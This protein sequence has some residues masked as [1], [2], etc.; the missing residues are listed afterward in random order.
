M[1]RPNNDIKILEKSPDFSCQI[2]FGAGT[3]VPG[4][5]GTNAQGEWKY[6]PQCTEV[7]IN[8]AKETEVAI[9]DALGRPGKKYRCRK[10]SR[11]FVGCGVCGYVES[12]EKGDIQTQESAPDRALVCP[13]CDM[14]SAGGFM[15][16]IT[17][18]GLASAEFYLFDRDLCKYCPEKMAEFAEERDRRLREFI[19]W[20]LSGTQRELL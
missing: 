12:D 14:D 19:K 10:S 6:C 3:Y 9:W 16:F 1:K 8:Q 2:C 5:Q 15:P 13:N 20:L 18:D 4:D 17:M 11:Q 7:K